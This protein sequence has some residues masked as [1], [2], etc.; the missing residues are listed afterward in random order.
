VHSPGGAGGLNL[1]VGYPLLA[2]AFPFPASF[3]AQA[4]HS[5][6][7]TFMIMRVVKSD[8]GEMGYRKEK[9]NLSLG[10]ELSLVSD[11]GVEQSFGEFQKGTVMHQKV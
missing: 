9:N 2:G 7:E 4:D 5:I 10:V 8:S 1:T 11:G 6:I 3:E